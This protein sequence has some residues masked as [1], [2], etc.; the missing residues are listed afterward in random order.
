MITISGYVTDIDEDIVNN[1]NLI[2][3]NSC[4]YYKMVKRPHFD[5]IRLNGRLDYQLLYVAKGSANFTVH[6]QDHTVSEGS[7]VIYHP[8]QPQLYSYNLSQ[9]TEVYW[10]HFSGAGI[11]DRIDRLG[12]KNSPFYRVGVKNAYIEIFEKIIKEL[13]LRAE[14]FLELSDLYALELLSLMSR[15]LSSNSLNPYRVNELIQNVIE[16]INKNFQKKQSVNEYAKLCSMSTCWF[17]NSF[18]AYTGITPQQ[19]ITNIRISK[20]KE[21]LAYSSFNITE[22]ASIVG[23]ENPFYFSRIFKKSTGLSP[24]EY[25]NRD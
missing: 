18:R 11:N 13:Q 14:H 3:V 23:Y 15:N 2:S 12:F 19:Y 5:T 4:G 17:I 1:E 7:I 6:G 24:R 25:K 21:L 20:A 9:N 10:L 16:L 22:I 8:Q